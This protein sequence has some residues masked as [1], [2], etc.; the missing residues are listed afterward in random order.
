MH[1]KCMPLWYAMQ[2]MHL[3]LFVMLSSL[4]LKETDSDFVNES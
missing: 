3:L 4:I 1:L 2:Y